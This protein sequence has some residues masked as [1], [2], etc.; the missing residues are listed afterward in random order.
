MWYIMKYIGEFNT[1]AFSH[2]RILCYVNKNVNHLNVLCV[3]NVL[4]ALYMYMRQYYYWNLIFFLIISVTKNIIPT[5]LTGWQ[6]SC[7]NEK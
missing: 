4:H 1:N 2:T 7:E 5:R 6:L 3:L